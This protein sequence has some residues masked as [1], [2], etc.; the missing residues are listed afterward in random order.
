MANATSHLHPGG[1]R[2]VVEG[3]AGLHSILEDG[4]KWSSDSSRL[5][6]ASTPGTDG[7]ETVLFSPPSVPGVQATASLLESDDHFR[8]SSRMDCREGLSDGA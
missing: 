2:E 8:P 6:I 5:P 3:G 4:R 1:V 7:G